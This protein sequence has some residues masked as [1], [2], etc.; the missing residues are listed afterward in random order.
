MLRGGRCRPTALPHLEPGRRGGGRCYPHHSKPPPPAQPERHRSKA[1]AT[2]RS[3]VDIHLRR[4]FTGTNRDRGRTTIGHLFWAMHVRFR[5]LRAN[6][7]KL[8]LRSEATPVGSHRSRVGEKGRHSP[9]QTAT[10]Y[11]AFSSPCQ[12]LFSLF[13]CPSGVE[14]YGLMALCPATSVMLPPAI[15]SSAFPGH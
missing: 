6:G 4:S 15:F 12:Q 10:E 7:E 5:G 8:G 2:R 13:L 9:P 14:V 3:N 11:F 1:G